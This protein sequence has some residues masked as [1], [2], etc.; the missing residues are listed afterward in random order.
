MGQN[1]FI[2]YLRFARKCY[3]QVGDELA[4]TEAEGELSSR[5]RIS[6]TEAERELSSRRKLPRRVCRTGSL[7][8]LLKARTERAAGQWANMRLERYD[9]AD[10]IKELEP[11]CKYSR[12]QR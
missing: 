3:L 9:L 4:K 5:G 10:P 6:R 11:F 1:I 8:M 12:I 7:V 2:K